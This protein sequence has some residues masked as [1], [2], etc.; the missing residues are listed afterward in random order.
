MALL[1]DIFIGAGIIFAVYFISVILF[2]NDMDD[3]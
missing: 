2:Y 3:Y 1:F